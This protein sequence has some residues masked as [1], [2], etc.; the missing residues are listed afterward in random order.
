MPAYWPERFRAF[1]KRKVTDAIDARLE[2]YVSDPA[3]EP[4]V[5]SSYVPIGNR[6]SERLFGGSFYLAPDRAERAGASLVFVQS[7]DGNTATDDPGELG[8]GPTDKHLVYEGLS[9]VAADG[10]LAGAETIRGGDVMFSVWHPEMVDLRSRLGLPRHPVQIVA[11]LR[12]LA[13]DTMLLNVPAFEVVIV[14]VGEVAAA[15]REPLAERPWIRVVAMKRPNDLRQAF[16]ELGALGIRRIS[17][18]GGR[19]IAGALVD[20][21]VVDD[22]YLTTS[23]RAGGQP[24]TPL[25]DKPLARELCLR[26]LGTGTDTGL[27]FEHFRMLGSS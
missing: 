14:T 8:G 10:V 20:A 22:L 7:S 12:G 13:F 17:A 21:G 3:V 1:E 9:R 11:T 5:P 2:P 27:Q 16:V 25:Y 23:S 6:W 18:V 15:I 4:R 19:T 26:K 24:N